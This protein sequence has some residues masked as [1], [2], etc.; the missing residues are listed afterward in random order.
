MLK[1]V[2]KYAIKGA[3][4]SLK[5]QTDHEKQF[6][7]WDVRIGQA[8]S[9]T[10]KEHLLVDYVHNNMQTNSQTVDIQSRPTVLSTLPSAGLFSL[11]IWLDC[12]PL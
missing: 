5:T 7:N 4:R 12:F 2:L 3:V 9:N 11:C 1:Y 8:R 10:V 6:H